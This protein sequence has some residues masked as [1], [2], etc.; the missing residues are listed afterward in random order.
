MFIGNLPMWCTNMWRQRDNS[1]P[2]LYYKLSKPGIKIC[3]QFLY[4]F[5]LV[6][7]WILRRMPNCHYGLNWLSLNLPSISEQTALFCFV[8][9]VFQNIESY[10]VVKAPKL[11][12]LLDLEFKDKLSSDCRQTVL[13]SIIKINTH[14]QICERKN[15][16]NGQ[17]PLPVCI[18]TI[19]DLVT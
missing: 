5:P 14:F 16:E 17:S 18:H 11:L 10:L 6:S 3:C 4:K 15:T 12:V 7:N 9:N 13:L 19:Y 1:G 8:D 2:P